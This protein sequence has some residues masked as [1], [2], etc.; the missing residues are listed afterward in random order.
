MKVCELIEKLQN[1]PE[2]S[3]KLDVTLYTDHGQC[4]IRPD[5]VQHVYVRKDDLD[6]AYMLDSIS[7]DDIE[8]D[9][10]DDYVKIIEIS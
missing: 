8:E 3:K 10:L 5:F 1:L 6:N 4:N 9:E 7:I 2:E